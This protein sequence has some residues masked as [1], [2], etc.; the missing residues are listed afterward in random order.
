MPR[1]PDEAGSDLGRRVDFRTRWPLPGGV[2]SPV[3]VAFR[4]KS[5]AFQ[6]CLTKP[7]DCGP[8]RVLRLVGS[9]G[10]RR[11]GAASFV[12]GPQ[13]WHSA[14][15]IETGPIRL[16]VK[17]LRA[18]AASTTIGAQTMRIPRRQLLS[19]LMAGGAGLL[20]AAPRGKARA[21]DGRVLRLASSPIGDTGDWSGFVERTGWSVDLHAISD[22]SED[23]RSL[24]MA[25]AGEGGGLDL[26]HAVG[27]MSRSLVTNDLIDPLETDRLKNWASNEYIQTYF[28]PD[29]PGFSYIGVLGKVVAAPTVLQGDSFAYL[30]EI[31][32]KLDSYAALFRSGMEGARCRSRQ[33]L[34]PG[35]EDRALSQ[36]QRA[37]G[38]RGSRRHDSR[39][40]S[41]ASST[42]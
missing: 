27:G 32:G 7:W 6:A 31:T 30:P 19:L 12:P 36:G 35:P 14:G 20:T 38:D 39:P 40:R 26:I 17:E 9:P 2:L 18:R 4:R 16:V 5:G 33:H 13:P 8:Q 3:G 25:E 15:G 24:L 23:I 10:A 1:F 11:L 42:S 28:G 22:A 29:S 34:D 37:R 21:N 41:A